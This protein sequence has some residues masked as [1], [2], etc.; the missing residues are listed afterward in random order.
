MRRIIPSM[1]VPLLLLCLGA[2]RISA[3]QRNPFLGSAPEGEATGPPLTL[4]L[5]DALERGLRQNLGVLLEEQRLHQVE[6]DR[7]RLLA[8]LLPDASAAINEARQK[9]NLAAFGF[10]G[11]PGTP[12]VIGPFNVFDARVGVTQPVLDIS[13][14]YEARQGSAQLRAGQ[15]AYEDARHVVVLVVTGLYLQVIASQSRVDAARAES[16]TAESLYVLA[17]DQNNAGVVPRLDVLRADVERKTAAQRRIAAE[18]ETARAR[19]ALARAIGLP[20]M[21]AYSLADAMAYAPL[22]DPDPAMLRQQALAHRPDVLRAQAEVEAARASAS[23]ARAA[24]LPSVTVDGNYGWIGSAPATAEGTFAVAANVHV[25][26]FA[27]GETRA[28]E[29]DAQAGLRQRELQLQDLR[30]RVSYEI[31]TALRDLGAAAQQVDVARSAT[32][33]A[34]E[35]LTQ[36]R[37]R[38]GAGVATN[39]E[40]VQAQQAAA[41]AREGY[42]AAL[43]AHNIAKAVLA[44]AVGADEQ[45]FI[46]ILGGES[47]WTNRR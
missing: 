37:D 36:A 16:A 31:D 18:N 5:A 26:L 2:A 13:A 6:G 4:S 24:R 15:H 7:W 47:P 34:A 14:I 1:A 39:I 38:F 33:A 35:A 3:Q 25:P 22:Q 12:D 17:V 29:I 32:D 9:V 45:Q 28:R 10:S 23:A 8:G 30:A 21:Q 46:R 41:A 11:F 19:T 40:V 42:I 20:W 44:K 43:Y 27:A